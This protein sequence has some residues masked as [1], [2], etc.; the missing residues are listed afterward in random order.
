MS[1]LF[2]KDRTVIGRHIRTS[3]RRV[4]CKSP[5]YVQNLHIPRITVV[6]KDLHKKQQQR[7]TILMLSFL[8]VTASRVNEG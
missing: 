5:W 2:E 3:S 1:E 6:E 7:C 8:W 4:N